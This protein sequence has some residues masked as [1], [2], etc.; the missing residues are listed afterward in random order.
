MKPSWILLLAATACNSY[1][2]KT[3]AFV[4]TEAC[5]QGPFDVVLPADAT[6]GGE[7]ME[8]IA[9]TPRR[10]AGHVELT[11]GKMPFRASS[12][13]DVADNQRCLAGRPV[14]ITQTASAASTTTASGGDARRAV[15][16]TSTNLVERPFTGSETPFADELCKDYGMMAQTILDTTTIERTDDTWLEHGDPL[17]VRIWS[18]TPNDLEG[19]VFM[20]RQV[21]DKR[22]TAQVA[23]EQAAEQKKWEREE[24]EGKHAR[25]AEK[26]RTPPPPAPV[27]PPAP[28]VEARPPAPSLQ[29]TWISGYWVRSGDRWGWIAGF[30][31]DDRFSPPPP[32]VEIPGAPPHDGAVWIGGAWTLRAGVQVWI[33]GRWR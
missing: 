7:G 2:T 8:V 1:R 30:W 6:T 23:K 3:H 32:Q 24:R 22:S 31:R 10:L 29:A 9:C 14:V 4:A 26:P 16:A 11:V 5:G 17:H 19:V 27:A 13:G 28:L 15:H 12:F 20:V 18:D 25:V 33:S 21:I